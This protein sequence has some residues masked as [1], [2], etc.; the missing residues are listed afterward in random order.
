[1]AEVLKNEIPEIA[2]VTKMT[3]WDLEGVFE[4]ESI[5]GKEK[6]GRF[7]SPDFFRMFSFPLAEGDPKSALR[8]PNAI[9]VSQSLAHKYFGN[10]SS[11]G[12]TIRMHGELGGDFMV[13]GVM[14]DVPRHS[15]M[16]FDYVIPIAFFEQKAAWT[17]T[18]GNYSF[19]TCITL[20]PDASRQRV[21]AKIKHLLGRKNKGSKDELFLQPFGEMYLYSNFENGRQAGGRIEYVRLFLLVAVFVLV[22]A[23]INFMNLATARS[24]KR[25]KEV[26]IRKVVG[27]SRAALVRQFIGEALLMTLLAMGLSIVLVSLLLPPFN[28]LMSKQIAFTFNAPFLLQLL[29]IALLTGLLSGSY[30]ALFLSGLSPLRVL[31]GTLKFGSGAILFRKGLVVFQFALSILLTVGSLLVYRQIQYVKDKNLGLDRENVVTLVLEGESGKRQQAFGQEVGRLPGVQSVTMSSD[32]PTWVGGVSSDLNWAGKGANEVVKVAGLRVGYDFLATLN[33]S[34]KEGRDFSRQFST[35]STNYIVN[36]AA[37]KA[38]RMTSPLGQEISFW[39]GKGKVIGVVKD[40]HL[41]SLH[42]A[43]RPLV[44]MLEPKYNSLLLVK[45]QPGKTAQVLAGLRQTWHDYNPQYPFEYHFLD[46]TFE[47]QYRSE[48]LVGELAKYFA[49]LAIFISCLGLFGLAAFTAE[50]RTKEIGIRKV[51]GASV[52]GLVTLL[53]REFVKLMGIAFVAATPLAWYFAEQ[54]LGKFA[55]R[56]DM[57]WWIFALAGGLALLIALLTV[58]FH[59]IRAALANPVKS[60]RSE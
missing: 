42:E 50:Q 9:V 56:T 39:N 17:K 5:T 47:N 55:Y 12:R 60:L 18:W 51:L 36:E 29:G 26:G 54:W 32:N 13:T 16:Q 33:I 59:S 19:F 49:F 43:I 15:S 57:A 34:L 45:T 35:D 58:S 20:R 8:A 14:Q 48:T 6:R 24:A 3:N 53:S 30:P 1:L 2:Y 23:C 41:T 27:G 25:T 52:T 44:I 46:E 10:A 11:L 37:V 22:I 21:E 38:M 7:A 28:A 4:V 40:F 31:K